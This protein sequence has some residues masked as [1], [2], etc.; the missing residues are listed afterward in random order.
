MAPSPRRSRR[1]EAEAVAHVCSFCGRSFT[2][3]PN[4]SGRC[5]GCRGAQIRKDREYIVHP[6]LAF[7]HDFAARVFVRMYPD[8]ATLEAIALVM[9]VT[10]ERLRQV[11]E[12]A[13]NHLVALCERD[14]EAREVLRALL[15]HLADA[16]DTRHANDPAPSLTGYDAE[17]EETPADDADL[18]S[19]NGLALASLVEKIETVGNL[20]AEL[21]KITDADL[22]EARSRAG[23]SPTL[24]SPVE[25]STD[26]ARFDSGA[27]ASEE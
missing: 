6:T 22:E 4:R 20:L 3:T 12:L 23:S 8:G 15:H 10:R 2:T 24:V 13:L 25:D 21:Y 27:A 11:E 26:G 19:E 17:A 16:R 9:S 18:H 5:D 7:E 1:R 14:A